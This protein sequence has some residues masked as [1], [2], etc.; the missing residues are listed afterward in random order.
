MGGLARRPRHTLSALVGAV[1]ADGRDN[2]DAIRLL[3]PDVDIE[4]EYA[5]R[6]AAG[7]GQRLAGTDLYEDVRPT[8]TALRAAGIRV[9]V[10]GN[11]SPT[12]GAQL[13]TAS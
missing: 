13:A 12:A 2:A 8:L 7:R 6:E 4:A 11:Q 1:V 9:I 5:A 3:R 10:A